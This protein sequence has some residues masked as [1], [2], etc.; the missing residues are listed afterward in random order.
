MLVNIMGKVE[1]LKKKKRERE[2]QI[3]TKKQGKQIKETMYKIKLH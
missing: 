3:K 2:M 1:V